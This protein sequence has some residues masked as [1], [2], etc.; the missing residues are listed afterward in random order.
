[1]KDATLEDGYYKRHATSLESATPSESK[2][3][4]ERKK[5][6]SIDSERLLEPEYP[7]PTRLYQ[8]VLVLAG[9]LA[10]FQTIGLNQTYGIF[11]ASPLAESL[12]GCLHKS[13][14]L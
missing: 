12:P 7:R 6:A 2:Y 3:D 10:T 5:C 8:S 9:F 11:Q 4:W 14:I 13:Y 1:M